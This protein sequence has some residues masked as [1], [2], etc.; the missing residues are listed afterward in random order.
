MLITGA[1]T[2]EIIQNTLVRLFVEHY[3]EEHVFV[4]NERLLWKYEAVNELDRL[5]SNSVGKLFHLLSGEIIE[6]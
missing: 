2:L 5:M 4:V 1:W 3:F 6:I